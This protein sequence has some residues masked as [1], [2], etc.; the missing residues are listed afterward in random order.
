MGS[1]DAARLQSTYSAVQAREEAHHQAVTIAETT[2]GA[3]TETNRYCSDMRGLN[4]RDDER[5]R[6]DGLAH[7]G[8]RE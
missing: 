6:H 1:H 2:D 5:L 8:S 7:D 4:G 3:C